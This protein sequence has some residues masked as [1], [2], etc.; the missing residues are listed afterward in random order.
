MKEHTPLKMIRS[1]RYKVCFSALVPELQQEVLRPMETLIL[2]NAEWCDRGNY[3][4]LCNILPTIAIDEV[5]VWHPEDPKDR[6][7]FETLECLYWHIFTK[8]GVL[9]RFGL[10]FC[11]S[12]IINYGNLHNIDFIRT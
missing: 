11:R 1:G 8:Y 2:E 12:D 10:M 7:H 3:G 9:E 4:H 6:Y 5:Y